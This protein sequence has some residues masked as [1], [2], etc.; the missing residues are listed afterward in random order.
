MATNVNFYKGD[1]FPTKL[2]AEGS[3]ILNNTDK[4]MWYSDGTTRY[5]I[6][7]P[8]VTVTDY[9]ANVE[10]PESISPDPQGYYIYECTVTGIT[11][12]D[13]PIADFY[14]NPA[15]ANP[16]LVNTMLKDWNKV[17][18]IETATDKIIVY[19]ASAITSDFQIILK[20]IGVR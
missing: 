4:T 14:I 16:V 17:H 13:E 11:S 20:T 8:G 9:I 6:D 3:F 1:G 10:V 12:D 18:R 2:P 7:K 19:A 5:P 15:D